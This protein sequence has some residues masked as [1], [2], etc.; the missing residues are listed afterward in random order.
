MSEQIEAA[1]YIIQDIQGNA[2]HGF[3]DTV[4]EAWQMVVDSVGSF[5]NAYGKGII[6]LTP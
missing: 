4:D 3:G 2:I 6:Y 5:S 1:G